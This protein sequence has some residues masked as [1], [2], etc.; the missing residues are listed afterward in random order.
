MSIGQILFNVFALFTLIAA[1]G[2]VVNKNAVNASLGQLSSRE[3]RD[4]ARNHQR[5]GEDTRH[6]RELVQRR[7]RIPA[8]VE[9]HDDEEKQ[10]RN[11]A[12]VNQ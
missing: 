4:D 3:K 7:P 8:R 12:R 1:V 2:V 10:R 9:E 11:R 6:R 5:D